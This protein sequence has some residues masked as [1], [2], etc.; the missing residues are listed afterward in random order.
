MRRPRP[1]TAWLTSC[2]IAPF[3]L[4][5]AWNLYEARSQLLDRLIRIFDYVND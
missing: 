1:R 2:A 5:G 3:V 4:A